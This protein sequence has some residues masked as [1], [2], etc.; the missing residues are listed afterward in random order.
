MGPF[1]SQSE[2]SQNWWIHWSHIRLFFYNYS[3]ASGLLIAKTMQSSC[4][5]DSRFIEKVKE[6]LSAGTSDSPKNIF[7]KIG[8]DITDEKFWK[9][10]LDKIDEYLKKTEKLAKKLE[11]I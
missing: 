9:T 1:V 3:Y 6:F 8:I 4:A 7:K 2:G 10:G 5:K 11:K